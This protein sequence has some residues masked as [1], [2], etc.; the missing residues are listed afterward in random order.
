MKWEEFVKKYKPIKNKV[1]G[2]SIDGYMFET[3][4]D[5]LDDLRTRARKLNAKEPGLYIWTLI[6]NN[7]GE[8]WFLS[9]GMHWV[10]RIGYLLT[11]V[12]WEKDEEIEVEV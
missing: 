10:N 11:K 4:G 5:E 9:N 6:D 3:F 12:P 1:K 2:A 7:D 8:D